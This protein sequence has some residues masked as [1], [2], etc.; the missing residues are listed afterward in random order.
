MPKHA[1][2]QGFAFVVLAS[3]VA[4]SVA[5]AA[6]SSDDSLSTPPISWSANYASR[7]FWQGLDYSAGRPVLQPQVTATLAGVSISAWGNLDQTRRELDE[8]DLGLQRDWNLGKVSGALGYVHL[9]YPHRDW[10]ATHELFVDVAFPL[11]LEPSLSM[12]WDVG[13]GAGRTWTLGVEH[14]FPGPHASFGVAS[15]L[16]LHDSYYDRSGVPAIETSVSATK[17]LGGVSV[18][19]TLARL[20]TWANGDYRDDVRVPGGWVLGVAFGSP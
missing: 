19:P 6:P 15:K 7:Y 11:P 3:I 14:E 9:R 18:Q 8:I 12:H 20:W 16:Y 2:A 4:S 13:A 5:A 1:A 10:E 17:V